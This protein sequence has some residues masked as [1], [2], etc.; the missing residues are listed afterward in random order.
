[1]FSPWFSVALNRPPCLILLDRAGTAFRACDHNQR[2][3]CYRGDSK[4][5]AVGQPMDWNALPEGQ[6]VVT[7]YF[8][9]TRFDAPTV[10][11]QEWSDFLADVVTPSFI[12][13]FTVF[14]GA[15][16]YFN[17]RRQAVV[18]IRTKALVVTARRAN[19]ADID[20]IRHEYERRFSQIAVGL[21]VVP[22]HADFGSAR[23]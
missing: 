11:E 7:L 17:R 5:R 13:G 20:R 4:G 3:R 12:D 22:G 1:M 9:L 19:T 15:G 16:Q 21:T 10:T 18:K 6:W 8:G 23:N 2:D 14:D